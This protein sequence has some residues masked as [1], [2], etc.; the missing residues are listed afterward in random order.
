MTCVYNKFKEKI[1]KNIFYKANKIFSY[2]LIKN[3]LII[4]IIYIYGIKNK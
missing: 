3:L 2:F 1:K 4:L